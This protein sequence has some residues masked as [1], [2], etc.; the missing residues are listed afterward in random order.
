MSESRHIAVGG[1]LV[2]SDRCVLLREPTGHFAGYVWTFAKGRPN[3]T[4]S[5]EQA[6]LREVLEETGYSARIIRPI[7]GFFLTPA[8]VTQFFLMR[9][10]AAVSSPDTRETT[11]IKWVPI[12]EASTHISLTT[13]AH[14]RERDLLAL[15]AATEMLDECC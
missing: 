15:S 10:I 2:D 11:T 13:N 12:S 9:P 6:A 4:E 1:I 14:G 3:A 8:S 5:N 7:P